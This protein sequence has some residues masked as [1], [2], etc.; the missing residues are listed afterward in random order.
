MMAWFADIRELTET[1]SEQR[2][3]FVRRTHARSMSGN[4]FKPASIGGSSDGGMEEDE[5][6][7]V[8]M[9]TEQSMRGDSVPA[10]DRTAIAG[11]VGLGAAAAYEGDDARSEAGWRPPQRPSP[12]GRFPSEVNVDRGLQVPLSPSSGEGSDP[13]REA[14][15]AAGG[16]PGSG[17]PFA[18]HNQNAIDAQQTT[19]TRPS[20]SQQ[21]APAS[22]A[23][24]AN[25]LQPTTYP[26]NQVQ[27]P[28]IIGH[29]SGQPYLSNTDNEGEWLA[30]IAAGAGG[31]ALGAGA[32]HH[33]N[34]QKE[35]QHTADPVPQEMDAVGISPSAD[36]VAAPIPIVNHAEETSVSA[37]SDDSPTVTHAGTASTHG[38]SISTVPTSVHADNSTTPNSYFDKNGTGTAQHTNADSSTGQVLT[39]PVGKVEALGIRPLVTTAQSTNTISDLHVPGEFPKTTM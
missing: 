30:P 18:G 25:Q 9:S 3:A 5:A 14:L 19:P 1:T 11:G 6:D 35:T 39:P 16:L 13:D 22:S 21:A 4:S 28:N 24:P 37:V 31:A 7:R 32:V 23:Y 27:H 38:D 12:G 34:Q 33:R 15:A 10:G 36:A 29:S 17:V 8:P 26:N 20:R 2:N